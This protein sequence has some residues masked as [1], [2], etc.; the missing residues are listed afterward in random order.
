M[1]LKELKGALGQDPE[2]V[3]GAVC[4]KETRAPVSRLLDY[5]EAGLSIGRYLADYPNV[6]CPSVE[7]LPQILAG[8]N[9][10]H[11]ELDR[12]A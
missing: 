5:Q 11:F 8:E 4:H 6:P 10:T 9:R 7:G 12:V 2:V 1:I 3:H